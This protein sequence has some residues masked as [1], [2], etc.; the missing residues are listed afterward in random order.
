MRDAGGL[1]SLMAGGSREAKGF[2]RLKESESVSSMLCWMGV[3][4]GGGR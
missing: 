1:V 3:E 2:E 4:C